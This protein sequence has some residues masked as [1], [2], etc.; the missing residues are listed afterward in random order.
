MCDK[1]Y[2]M[3]RHGIQFDNCKYSDDVN[4]KLKLEAHVLA[5]FTISQHKHIMIFDIWKYPN[6]GKKR[7]IQE[8][9]TL[10][11]RLTTY[12]QFQKGNFCKS[13]II[14]FHECLCVQK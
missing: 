8:L 9:N 5:I 1:L 7:E 14:F 4:A 13:L 11:S 2:K 12:I 6:R 10:K 3:G